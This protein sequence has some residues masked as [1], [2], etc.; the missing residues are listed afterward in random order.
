MER[1][2]KYVSYQEAI[3]SNTAI[4][5]GIDNAP[6]AAQ[7]SAMK[8]VAKNVFDK[9]REHFGV[10]I[11]VTSFFRSKELNK[12]IG[13]ASKSDHMD[14]EAIDIDADVYGEIT[15][16]DI[17]EYIKDS[18]EFDK[19]IWEFGS[20]DNPAWVHVSYVEGA[21]RKQVMKAIRKNGKT[22]YIFV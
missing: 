9:T 8:T 12:K 7:L 17:F 4:K 5:N 18:L 6:D 10:P 3:K 22:S 13:G 21:N 16:K 11:A 20:D 1:I 15:N 2:S 14:G 19:L